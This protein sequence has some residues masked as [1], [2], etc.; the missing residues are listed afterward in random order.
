MAQLKVII[1]TLALC[2]VVIL[3]CVVYNLYIYKYM[4]YV[5]SDCVAREIL[6]V[7]SKERVYI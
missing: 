3:M 7:D 4:L 5:V 2:K 6:F 1:H